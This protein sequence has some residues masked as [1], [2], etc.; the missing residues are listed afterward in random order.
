M[1]LTNIFCKLGLHTS[2]L[3]PTVNVARPQMILLVRTVQT[4]QTV[5]DSLTTQATRT[6]STTPMAKTY[7]LGS[8][9]LNQAQGDILRYE[10]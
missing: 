9:T 1:C 2:S 6:I 3:A 8:V 7:R 5:K 10:G 4:L